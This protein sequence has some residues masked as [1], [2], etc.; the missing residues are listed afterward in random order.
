MK[1]VI[2]IAAF[3]L[4]IPLIG[5]TSSVL[6]PIDN[7]YLHDDTPFMETE[8]MVLNFKKDRV[9]TSGTLLKYGKKYLIKVDGSYYTDIYTRCDGA[10][11]SAY[12]VF[13]NTYNNYTAVSNYVVALKYYRPTPDKYDSTG[14]YYYYVAGNNNHLTISN[15]DSTL[16]DNQ[17]VL[18]FTILQEK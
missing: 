17:G 14:T 11:K 6:E 10:F 3:L 15:I 1:R 18:Y 7:T 5:C 16:Y 9:I 2:F 4:I 13:S 12:N 8:M